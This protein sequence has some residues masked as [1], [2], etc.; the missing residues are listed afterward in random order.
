MTLKEL[1]Y[2]EINKVEQ[3]NLDELYEFVKQFANA[4]STVKPKTGILNK[5]KRIKI[6]APVDFATNIDQY[7]SGEKNLDNIH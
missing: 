7:M 1:I 2:A 4:K 6:Q 5:L 3:D